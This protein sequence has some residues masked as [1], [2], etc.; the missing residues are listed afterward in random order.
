MP[1]PVSRGDS[2]AEKNSEML[3]ENKTFG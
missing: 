1:G 3:K 2:F